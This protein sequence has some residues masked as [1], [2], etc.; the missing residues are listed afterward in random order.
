MVVPLGR[1]FLS[2]FKSGAWSHIYLTADNGLDTLGLAGLVK[3][4]NSVHNSMVCDGTGI[5]AKF[6]DSS[7]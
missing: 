5:H 7:N 1:L 2:L 3:F 6:L 4:Y